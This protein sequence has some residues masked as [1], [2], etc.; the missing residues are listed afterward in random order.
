MAAKPIFKDGK[1]LWDL[2]EVVNFIIETDK[3][4]KK[5]EQEISKKLSE[6][7]FEHG[8]NDCNDVT[9]IKKIFVKIFGKNKKLQ[10]ALDIM[11]KLQNGGYENDSSQSSSLNP[12]APTFIPSNN[13]LPPNAQHLLNA[14][15]KQYIQQTNQQ[16]NQMNMELTEMKEL[17]SLCIAD[18]DIDNHY[19]NICGKRKRK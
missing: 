7:L 6:Y 16:H 1:K 12:N 17:A 19:N 2:Q 15:L 11:E 3:D 10:K 9:A 18:V 4:L 5:K 8:H 13:S 14:Q